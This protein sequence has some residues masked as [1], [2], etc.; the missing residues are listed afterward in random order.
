MLVKGRDAVNS[1][2]CRLTAE[3][4]KR[5][6]GGGGFRQVQVGC[7]KRRG[8]GNKGAFSELTAGETATRRR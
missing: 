6:A 5:D 8:T 7:D 2:L 1:N 3:G 4:G